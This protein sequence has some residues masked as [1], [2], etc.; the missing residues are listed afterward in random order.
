MKIAL[1][2]PKVLTFTCTHCCDTEQISKTVNVDTDEHDKWGMAFAWREWGNDAFNMRIKSLCVWQSQGLTC[3][4]NCQETLHW[5][6]LQNQHHYKRH[7]HVAA[8]QA[9]S[10]WW[11]HNEFIVLS[12]CTSECPVTWNCLLV[13]WQT[14]WL[15]INFITYHTCKQRKVKVQSVIAPVEIHYLL[16]SINQLQQS[17]H[18]ETAFYDVFN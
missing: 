13:D 4:A 11:N 9:L 10:N 5:D 2:Q 17:F 15:L 7:R 3:R 1:N 6:K 12:E 8:T 16:T 18:P 14:A